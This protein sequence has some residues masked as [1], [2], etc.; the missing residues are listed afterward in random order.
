ML[1]WLAAKAGVLEPMEPHQ[2]LRQ[3]LFR[4]ISVDEDVRCLHAVAPGGSN[5]MRIVVGARAR[6][7]CSR[8]G[9]QSLVCRDCDKSAGSGARARYWL[10]K[11]CRVLLG[12]AGVT[13][14]GRQ[15]RL[16]PVRWTPTTSA[17]RT[18]TSIALQA[19]AEAPTVPTEEESR[20]KTVPTK[21][22]P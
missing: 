13:T 16:G 9:C 21:V 10:C 11:H 5:S 7:V 22:L 8:P 15:A 20:P 12:V 2:K 18:P 19:P 1:E 6:L 3:T 14:K 4:F 17:T